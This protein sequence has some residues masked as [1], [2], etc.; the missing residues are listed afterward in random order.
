MLVYKATNKINGK[1]YIGYTSKTLEYR[2]KQHLYKSRIEN[3][4]SY[5]YLFKLAIRKHSFD[6][7]E[8]E[9]L[10]NCNSI[11]ECCEKEIFYIKEFNTIS[12]NGYNLTDG[13]N[14]GMPSEETKLKISSSLKKYFLNNPDKIIKKEHNKCVEAGKK[15]A[16][17][18]KLN[19]YI[20]P[21]G[22]KM[23]EEAKLNMSNAKNNKNKLIWFNNI[24][25]E[26]IELSMLKMSEY[27][28]LSTG[29]FNHLKHGRQIVTKCGW[30]IIK[31][32]D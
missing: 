20:A 27:T 8:W 30:S 32:K 22:Y 12:P 17:T 13:G 23:T 10:C 18:K 14:G 31:N 25:N 2:K 29:T 19:G 21:K 3:D 6:S 24:T 26:T 9:V 5:F 28:G 15:A 1:C 7:F 4:K 16:L 11:E